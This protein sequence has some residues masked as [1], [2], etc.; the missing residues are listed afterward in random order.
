MLRIFFIIIAFFMLTGAVIGGLYFWGVDPLSK[1]GLVI[2]KAPDVKG[3]FRTPEHSYVDFGL[4]AVP[5]I[6]DREVKAQAELIVRLDV[7]FEKK[8]MVAVN[9]PRLQAAYLEDMIGYLPS[10]FR[11]NG[12]RPISVAD[13]DVIAIRRRLQAVSDRVLGPGAVKAVEIEHT[14]LR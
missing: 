5:L 1:L 4:L 12:G 9:L 8:E 3:S 13:L 7:V 10:S 14:G 11:N 6:L 2:N